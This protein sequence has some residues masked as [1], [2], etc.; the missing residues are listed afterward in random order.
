MTDRKILDKYINLDNSC[1]MDMK[2]IEVRDMLY[3]YKEAF[4]LKD[5][6]GIYPN[7][8]ME[9]DVMDRA[10]FFIRPYHAKKE[11]KQKYIG[12]KDEE[13]VLHDYSTG[14]YFCLFQPR[15]IDKYKD[16]AR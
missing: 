7:V 11:D 9:I 16:E 5:E 14:G 1:L 6:I 4:S 3:E 8:E 15:K 10:S 2:K 12:P 13:M